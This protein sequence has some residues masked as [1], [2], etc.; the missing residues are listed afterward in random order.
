MLTIYILV[1]WMQKKIES[2]AMNFKRVTE[3]W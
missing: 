2:K 1:V 3:R